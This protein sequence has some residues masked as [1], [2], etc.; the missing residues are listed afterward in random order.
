MAM[1]DD[2]G[3]GWDE[4]TTAIARDQILPGQTN[5]S[6]AYLIV[7]AGSR[8]G[9]M[10]KVDGT[11]TIGRGSKADF[12]VSD[13]GVSRVHLKITDR[14]DDMIS[15]ADLASRNGTYINGQ[16]VENAVLQDGD[17]IQLGS[18]AI[19][20][21]SYA[22]DFEESFQQQMLNAALRDPLTGLY[23][24]RYMETQLESEFSYM[25]RHRTPLALIMMD[26]DHFKSF[27][28]THGHLVGDAVL[29][30]FAEALES[31]IRGEDLAARYGGEE[32]V[33][34]CR[35]VTGPICLGIANRIRELV[36][37]SAL[38]PDMPDLKVTVSAGVA[39]GPDPNI[40]N[41]IELIAAADASLYKAKDAGRNRV[42]LHDPDRP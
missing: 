3:D 17:K 41:A 31:A 20:K 27:N 25:L 11:V 24:R 12:R 22:D 30:G 33:L 34:V 16:K 32:F 18:T 15:V 19:L 7:L 6:K 23:N 40:R 37:T 4:T 1:N 13:H 10:V 38:V 35:G 21:F 28:D 8:V 14:G 29:K 36:E 39:A 9:E 5:K 26:I 42:V 2:F